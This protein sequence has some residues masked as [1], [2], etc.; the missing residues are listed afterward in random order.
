VT[1][2]H[3]FDPLPT[4]YDVPQHELNIRALCGV[5]ALEIMKPIFFKEK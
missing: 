5:R 2:K 1:Q 3:A 4:I